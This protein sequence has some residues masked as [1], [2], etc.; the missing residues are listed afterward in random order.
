[1][2]Y[3]I[4]NQPAYKIREVARAALAG[5]W[6]AVVLFMFLYYLITEGVSLV[7]GLFFFTTQTLPVTDPITGE[8][9]VG[10]VSYG[11]NIYQFLIGGPVAWGLSKY[12]LDFFREKRTEVTTLFEGFSHFGKAFWLMFLM[13]LKIFLWSLLLIIPGIIAAFRYSQAFYI[14]IDHP[15]YSANQCLKESSAMMQGNKGKFFYLNLTFI[16]WYLLA[17]IPGGIYAGLNVSNGLIGII[18]IIILSV[19]NMIVDVYANVAMTVFYELASDNL[20]VM[21]EG[22]GLPEGNWDTSSSSPS[23]WDRPEPARDE[24]ENAP[25]SEPSDEEASDENKPTE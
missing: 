4:V 11:S 21:E 17:S 13:G 6:Q 8:Y 7:L 14:L 16:G 19:P 22:Q 2:E 12:M 24:P 10:T 18:L 23:Y 15:E 9:M 5:N 1:M 3:R 25:Y 20:V